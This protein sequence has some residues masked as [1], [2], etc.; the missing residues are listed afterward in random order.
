[1][2]D[3]AKEVEDIEDLTIATFELNQNEL[4]GLYV[5]EAPSVKF[6][7]KHNKEPFGIDLPMGTKFDYL[8]YLQD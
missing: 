4:S 2:V 5:N 6:Y 7:P 3:L 1:M 8:H